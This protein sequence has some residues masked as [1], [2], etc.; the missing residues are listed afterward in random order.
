MLRPQV[1]MCMEI[2]KILHPRLSSVTANG[3]HRS[4]AL[5]QLRAVRLP[6]LWPKPRSPLGPRQTNVGRSAVK[7]M[8]KLE[9]LNSKY[10]GPTHSHRT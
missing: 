7:R 5:A 8:H 6:P 10:S 9:L 4:P 3:P 2:L 1:S